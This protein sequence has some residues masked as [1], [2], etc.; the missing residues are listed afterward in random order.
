LKIMRLEGRLRNVQSKNR[1]EN[2]P[3]SE[4]KPV[5]DNN[6]KKKTKQTLKGLNSFDSLAHLIR[7]YRKGRK[8]FE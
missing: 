7:E 8:N 5:E 6:E 4:K 1:S 3:Q 2:S